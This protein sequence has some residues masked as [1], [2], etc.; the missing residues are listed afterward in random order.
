MFGHAQSEVRQVSGDQMLLG[1]F[2]W[3]FGVDI[4][5]VISGFIMVYIS[6]RKNLFRQRGAWLS[7][8]TDRA[9][10]IA[11]VYWF[12][13]SAMLV[14][15]FVA[16][17]KLE[18]ASFEP[19]NTIA[20][21][22]FLPYPAPGGKIHPVLEVGWTLNYEMFFYVLF[23]MVIFLK[24]V[25]AVA[26]L[27]LTMSAIVAAG[28]LIKPDQF[29]LVFWSDPIILEFIFGCG[30]GFVYSRTRRY[31]NA[32][33]CLLL[34]A[35]SL[36]AVALLS[37]NGPGGYNRLMAQGVPAALLV[38]AFVWH[39]PHRLSSVSAPIAAFLGDS[40]YSLYLSHSFTLAIVKILWPFSPSM[41]NQWAYVVVATV[42]SAAVGYASYAL[43]EKPITRLLRRPALADGT[44]AP[45]AVS[46]ASPSEQPTKP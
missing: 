28:S 37:D 9:I 6:E 27:T 3:G 29:A 22:L 45:G 38:Y 39:M 26:V 4:F 43:L 12:Y 16:G 11:P 13:T 8:L 5:F 35:S 42:A 24:S 33:A 2:P 34:S 23:A 1:F 25:R 21:Y 41:G 15:I 7:F 40:S 46:N 18:T 17:S 32:L 30:L 31:P 44:A 19:F 36:V 20:S 10:R 14:A